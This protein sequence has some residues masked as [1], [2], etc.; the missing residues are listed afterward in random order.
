[1]KTK[2]NPNKDL[3]A[4]ATDSIIAVME[5]GKTSHLTWAQSGDGLPRNHQTGA[6]YQ[7]VNVLL[8]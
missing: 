6:V 2:A 4:Q 8:L 3:Y 7:G 5:S 1:M